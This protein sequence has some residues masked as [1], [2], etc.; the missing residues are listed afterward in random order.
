MTNMTFSI[1]CSVTLKI[2]LYLTIG[3]LLECWTYLLCFLVR[4]L[5]PINGCRVFFI[6]YL[7]YSDV[8]IT[9]ESVICRAAAQST[10]QKVA[11]MC[12]IIVDY[13]GQMAT[14]DI[15]PST[16]ISQGTTTNLC[17]KRTPGL[18]LCVCVCV[19]VCVYVCALSIQEVE[20]LSKGKKRD[21]LKSKKVKVGDG[22]RS[23]HVPS[24]SWTHHP[25]HHNNPHLSFLPCV[26]PPCIQQ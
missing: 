26:S 17:L 10:L 22:I 1:A 9:A 14:E 24:F 13:L 5:F 18:F 15:D 25:H 16:L 3:S 21:K 6:R 8:R 23:L 19:C 4:C 12:F 2:P 11:C 7:H 20:V